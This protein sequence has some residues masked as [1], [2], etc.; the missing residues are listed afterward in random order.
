MDRPLNTERARSFIKEVRP[1]TSTQVSVQLLDK[2]LMPGGF[3]DSVLEQEQPRPK[4]HISAAPPL[5]APSP[6]K[7][8]PSPGKRH[9]SPERPWVQMEKGEASKD[10]E[11]PREDEDFEN[12]LL[13]NT[14]INRAAYSKSSYNRDAVVI[15]LIR[16]RGALNQFP[17]IHSEDIASVRAIYQLL[18]ESR[19]K[20]CHIQVE[21]VLNPK[22]A[23]F[24]GQSNRYYQAWLNRFQEGPPSTPETLEFA[25]RLTTETLKFRTSSPEEPNS[26]ENR[27][28]P[29]GK[30]SPKDKRSYREGQLLSGQ[31]QENYDHTIRPSPRLFKT[32]RQPLMERRSELHQQRRG[33]GNLEYQ[34]FMEEDPESHKEKSHFRQTRE[35]SQSMQ[36]IYERPT[37]EVQ[38]R[39]PEGPDR[40]DPLQGH[41]PRTDVFAHHMDWKYDHRKVAPI[42]E[43][44]DYDQSRRVPDPR[45]DPRPFQDYQ[46]RSQ[47]KKYTD[48]RME[49]RPRQNIRNEYEDYVP[50]Q[51]RR[52]QFVSQNSEV[53]WLRQS[54]APEDHDNPRPWKQDHGNEYQSQPRPNKLRAHDVMTFDSEEHTAAFFIRRF[55]HI[56]EIEGDAAVLRVLLMC[57]KGAALEWHNSLSSVVRHEMNQNLWAWEDELLREYRPNRFE[58]LKKVKDLIFR[59]EDDLTLSQYLSRKTN[60]LHDAGIHDEDV[61]VSYLWE[62]LEPKLAL[63]TTIRDD[64]ETLEGFGRRVRRNEEAARR[65]HDEN[66]PRYLKTI[67]KK[68]YTKNFEADG[69]R[70]YEKKDKNI[71]STERV[72]KLLDKLSTGTSSDLKKE[73]TYKRPLRTT[74]GNVSAKGPPRP[75]RHCEGDHWD[76]DCNKNKDKDV[77]KVMII[78]EDTTDP[79][80]EDDLETY[81]VL[82]QAA[83]A[84]DE[85]DFSREE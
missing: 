23:S 73:E 43:Y 81:R 1:Q 44:Y 56:A 52:L 12:D 13:T 8:Q 28:R 69:H 53:R 47:S 26:L 36:P 42:S 19:K 11:R 66:K 71:I 2:I 31:N 27:L 5:M 74:N 17:G 18:S 85:N 33:L 14:E 65:V 80:S 68:S 39:K 70:K 62:G 16:K 32:Y 76:R 24:I 6:S 10:K 67:E 60:L 49:P 21:D 4:N 61:M 7:R 15:L 9:Q 83:A 78:D 22:S 51:N 35:Q 48:P 77:K 84:L 50:R 57:L 64:G 72:Q 59:F 38:A 30:R 82:E 58:S 55:Q 25:P 41:R 75:C 37:V 63:A 29:R 46:D 40:D 79:L 54:S 3:E 20:T 34:S 45:A